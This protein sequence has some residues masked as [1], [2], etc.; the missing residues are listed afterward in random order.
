VTVP[1]DADSSDG[2]STARRALRPLV[3]RAIGAWDAAVDA[4]RRAGPAGA[5][6]ERMRAACETRFADLPRAART[7][8]GKVLIDGTFDNPNYWYRVAVLR[9]ALG[10]DPARTVGLLGPH[11]RD[12]VR[13]TFE[14]YG[15]ARVVDL[16][17]APA[18]AREMNAAAR[19]LARATREPGD[20]LRWALPH[21]VDPAIVYDAILKR[22]RTA[23][24]DPAAREFAELAQEALGR[25]GRAAEILDAEKPDL[26]VMSHTVGMICGPLAFLAAAR[27]IPV[28]LA[29][30]HFGALRFARLRRPEDVF[31]FY[32]RPTGRD[33]DALAPTRA[34]AL[35]D[36]GRL[37]LVR[38]YGGEADDLASLYAFGRDRAAVARR[39]ICD[40]FGW[41]PDKPIVAVYA[42]NWFDWPHQLGMNRF[43][44]FHDWMMATRAAAAANPRCNWLFKP[45]PVED[46]FGGVALAHEIGDLSAWPHLRL[47]EKRW[48]NADVMNSID[49]LITYHGTA[50]IE[51]AALGKPVLVPDRGKY[52]DC[53]FV[54]V[55]DSREAYLAALEGPWWEGLDAAECKRRAEI[56]AGWWFC[57]PDWQKGFVL[58]DDTGRYENYGE[59]VRLLDAH[60]DALRA[61]LDGVAAWWAEGHPYFHTWKMGR[62]AAYR[63]SNV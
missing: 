49:A 33:I 4:L 61:E 42:A 57:I 6:A 14:R 31:A 13:R 52:D 32:D 2:A 54:K 39:D 9:A 27:G 38:R 28:V 3:R 47:A 26:V 15:T 23:K 11:R 58:P 22:Q 63:L 30:G 60:P 55:A 19:D 45:H 59:T 16:A 44:D 48:N 40:A 50:G 41:D 18:C 51:F 36:I 29:F 5:A 7:F 56:F 24:V 8:P 35:A 46:W 34:A 12:Y 53:G 1:R 62:S 43:R 17:A 10:F 25:I 37:Y 21:G 20:I